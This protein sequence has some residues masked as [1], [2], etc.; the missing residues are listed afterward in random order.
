MKT[1]PSSLF[2]ISLSPKACNKMFQIFHSMALI[3]YLAVAAQAT[4]AEMQPTAEERQQAKQY[5]Q[6]KNRQN[7]IGWK[8]ILFYCSIDNQSNQA[9]NEICER[10]YTNAEFLAAAAKINL[11]KAKDAYELCFRAVVGD[12]LVLEVELTAT[13]E[14]SPSAIHANLRAY[15][16]YS[17]SVDTSSLATKKKDPRAEPRLGDL[18]MWERSVI[19]A[20]SGAAQELIAGVSSGIEQALKQFFSD[21]LSAQR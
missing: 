5:Q 21:F 16:T 9:L 3:A 13:K 18:I 11:A 1:K 12:F 14:G 7:F 17:R 20:S 15:K 4:I 8:G 6:V 2:H 19:G 10:S